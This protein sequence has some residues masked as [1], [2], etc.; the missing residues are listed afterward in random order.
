MY[1]Q[2]A[3]CIKDSRLYEKISKKIDG[4]FIYEDVDLQSIVIDIE[5][6]RDFNRIK[7]FEHLKAIDED[8]F[9]YHAVM[10]SEN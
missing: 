2:S 10:I 5:D 4:T 3:L 9:L 8:I 7:D 1:C 6:I